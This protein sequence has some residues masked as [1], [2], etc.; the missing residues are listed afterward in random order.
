MKQYDL[1]INRKISVWRQDCISI[2]ADSLEAAIKKCSKGNYNTN[3][4]N[5]YY[6]WDT[7]EDIINSKGI[8]MKIYRDKHSKLPIY[9]NI[10]KND[11]PS[12]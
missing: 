12:K 1:I 7:E 8:V 9:S 3:Y 4:E 10:T 5:I 11:I 6:M 2:C